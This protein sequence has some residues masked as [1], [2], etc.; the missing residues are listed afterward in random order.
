MCTCKAKNPKLAKT[1]KRT[2]IIISSK[3]QGEE[4]NIGQHSRFLSRAAGRRKGGKFFF[5]YPKPTPYESQSWL[6]PNRA[7]SKSHLSLSSGP[8]SARLHKLH[9]SVSYVL[10]LF[11]PYVSAHRRN[12]IFFGATDAS[13]HA[14]NAEGGYGRRRKLQSLVF[15][16]L[17]HNIFFGGEW[18]CVLFFCIIP[19]AELLGRRWRQKRREIRNSVVWVSKKKCTE[20][21]TLKNRPRVR[22]TLNNETGKTNILFFCNNKFLS[23][24]GKRDAFINKTGNAY[25]RSKLVSNA[26]KKCLKGG[27]LFFPSKMSP[28]S[29]P[30]L[31]KNFLPKKKKV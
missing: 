8:H 2:E 23:R 4:L 29:I 11:Q 18:N 13:P 5:R 14:Q 3:I 21:C 12:I 7:I 19:P 10:P 1:K 27:F 9:T 25:S 26:I 15:S 22:E 31:N 24:R 28:G 30:P 20:Y 6:N 17:S 16:L